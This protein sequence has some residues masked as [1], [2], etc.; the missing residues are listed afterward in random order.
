MKIVKGQEEAT[1]LIVS[2]KIEVLTKLIACFINI[3][4]ANI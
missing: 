2:D 3:I 1:F 4:D